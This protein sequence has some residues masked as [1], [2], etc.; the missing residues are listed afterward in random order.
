MSEQEKL[1]ALRKQIKKRKPNFVRQC[2]QK[3][4]KIAKAWRRPKGIQSKMRLK[5]RGKKK[6]PSL[7]YSS[8]KKVRGLD[9][10]GYEEV[11]V[12]RV[13]DLEGIDSKKQ[14]VLIAKIGLKKKLMI[15]DECK[16]RNLNV[17]NVKDIDEFIKDSQEW[18]VER[19]K[20]TKERSKKRSAAKEASIKKAKGEEVKKK[21]E[22]KEEETKKGN[23]TKK[24]EKSDKIKILEQ[25]E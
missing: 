17:S 11:R 3:V 8:P 22:E 16:K 4:I 2:S 19:K 25:K 1:L 15:L 23:E 24:G 5:H 14:I 6:S 12:L 20:A 7:G 18:L 21:A 9:R 13:E 10:N